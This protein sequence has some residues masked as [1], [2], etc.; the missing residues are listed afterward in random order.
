MFVN[1][2]FSLSTRFPLSPFKTSLCIQ[3]LQIRNCV[4]KEKAKKKRHISKQHFCGQMT[5]SFYFHKVG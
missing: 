4:E 3:C 2:E 1:L 5:P